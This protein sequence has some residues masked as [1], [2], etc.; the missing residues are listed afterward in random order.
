MAE[1]YNNDSCEVRVGGAG[2]WV[3]VN[4]KLGCGCS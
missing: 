4:I 2:L 1:H 3:D